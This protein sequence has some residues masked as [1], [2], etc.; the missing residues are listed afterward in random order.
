MHFKV[1]AV[2]ITQEHKSLIEIIIKNNPRF[3]GNED[4]LDDFCGETLKR[5]C[6][7]INS[8]G[9]INSLNN[10]LSKV[11]TSAILEVLKQSGRLRR[12]TAGY[13]KIEQISTTPTISQQTVD[14][15]IFSI[16]DT[17]PSLEEQIIKEE[18]TKALREII[19]LLNQK[20]PEKNFLDLFVL[21]YL[22]G[23][24]Q[25]QIAEKIGISQ[26]EVSKRLI[27]LIKKI[28]ETVNSQ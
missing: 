15:I 21:R 11:S 22:E 9:E 2:E 7:I 4:L 1:S 27:E 10:Y 28:N 25:S 6:V 20:E 18:E 14:E 12:T 8:V 19:Y 24:K 16:P 3:S 13:Q 5:A 26:S 17:T 23:L